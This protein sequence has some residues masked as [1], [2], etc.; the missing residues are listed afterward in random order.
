MP[1]TL[2][3]FK[4]RYAHHRNLLARGHTEISLF[5]STISM[6]LIVWLA[7]RDSVTIRREWAFVVIPLIIL[8]AATIQYLVGYL[9]D[10]YKVIQDLQ[11]WD[12]SRNPLI[13]YLYD[14]AKREVEDNEDT[15]HRQL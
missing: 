13:Q 14:K 5:Y 8:V 4:K 3:R 11:E 6:S 7:I 9:M 15:L 2:S 12:F 10:R 1:N